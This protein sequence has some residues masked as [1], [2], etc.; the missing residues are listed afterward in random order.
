MSI[1]YEN[2]NRAIA[3]YSMVWSGTTSSSFVKVDVSVIGR[4]GPGLLPQH[5][6]DLSI[7]VLREWQRD[8]SVFKVLK[9]IPFIMAESHVWENAVFIIVISFCVGYTDTA[10]QQHYNHASCSYSFSHAHVS[11]SFALWF[12]F[13]QFCLSILIIYLCY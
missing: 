3:G 2:K 13:N 12:Y 7:P 10:D 11:F 4:G 5:R 9:A 8:I 6:G 1:Y